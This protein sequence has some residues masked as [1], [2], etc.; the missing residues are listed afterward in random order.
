VAAKSIMN[1][2]KR[3]SMCTVRLRSRSLSFPLDFGVIRLFMAF[4]V[5]LIAVTLGISNASGQSTAKGAANS[6]GT[7]PKPDVTA[8]TQT[9]LLAVKRICVAKLGGDEKF[10]EQVQEML[11]SSLF[12]SK[13]FSVTENC[14]R[15]DATLKGTATENKEVV[16]RLEDEGIGF[17]RV[18]GASRTSGAAVA[19]VAGATGETL[20]SSTVT[21]STNLAVRL[22]DH[23][24][25]VIWATMQES[26]G[27]KIRGPAA[28]L[29]DRAVKQLLRELEKAESASLT[30]PE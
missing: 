13:R 20:A 30:K 7:T 23:E 29:A 22:V 21:N 3:A 17:G 11:I 26:T 25:D 15:A 10:A 24:G 8:N 14:N 19:G 2:K 28:D 5:L 18:V 9:A 27:S 4:A 1:R 6:A 12:A 16:S